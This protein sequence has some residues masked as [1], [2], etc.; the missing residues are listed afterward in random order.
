MLASVAEWLKDLLFPKICVTC[1]I[2]GT[3]CCA[4]CID[5]LIPLQ[6]QACPQCHHPTS[7]GR[8]CSNCL[9]SSHLD[10]VFS[11]FPYEKNSPPERLI[12]ILKYSYARDVATVLPSVMQG[13]SQPLGTVLN[14]RVGTI[15]CIPVPLYIARERERGFNQS[16]LIAQAFS[17]VW[18][19]NE[20]TEV[21]FE[22]SAL[23]RSRA[24]KAQAM[25]SAEDRK[26]NMIGAFMWDSDVPSPE[27][28][29]LVDDVFTTGSTMQECAHI[30][31]KHGTKWVWGLTLAR[32]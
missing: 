13:A 15:V 20:L 6:H 3:W 28:V 14:G 1:G 24:T 19:K 18:S 11:L 5:E 4:G 10:G 32:G 17:R 7:Y 9:S 21:V 26:E 2:D 12:K 31:K 22:P 29:L 8:V 25:L 16:T 27:Q 30:L 23:K